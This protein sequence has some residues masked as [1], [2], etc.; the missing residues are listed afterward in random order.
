MTWLRGRA[1]GSGVDIALSEPFEGRFAG[2]VD[3]SFR[4]DD[5]AIEDVR[6]RVL[7]AFAQQAPAVARPRFGRP[8]RRGLAGIL[9]VS[10]SLVA[11]GAVAVGAEPGAPFYQVRLGVETATLPSVDAPA[12][13]QAR[14]DRLERRIG[15]GVM[16]GGRA[17]ASALVA[18]LGEYRVELIGLAAQ[19]VDPMRRSALLAAVARNLPVV[20]DLDRRYPSV[21]TELALGEIRTVVGTIDGDPGAD[22]VRPGDPHADGTVAGPQG[23]DDGTGDRHAGHAIGDPHAD[24]TTGNPHEDG[25][26]GNPHAGGST[27]NPHADGTTGNPHADGTTGNPHTGGATGNPHKGGAT[28]NPHPGTTG[29]PKG[30]SP[31]TTGK[32]SN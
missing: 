20:A 17:D 31:G 4:S 16:A 12:G 28:G 29:Q 27:G 9:A 8:A 18:A 32:P 7:A 19:P 13:W 5:D 15:E 10:A 21:A 22:E 2:L 23:V 26:T 11:F 6:S 1:T 24:G 25:T 14:L 3:R 30:K